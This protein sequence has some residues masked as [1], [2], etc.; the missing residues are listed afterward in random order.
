MDIKKINGGVILKVRNLS[1]GPG[2]FNSGQMGEL[3]V[4]L[5]RLGTLDL[6]LKLGGG[7]VK[8]VR[9]TIKGTDADAE[10]SGS[11]RLRQRMIYSYFRG[12][13]KFK[14]KKALLD[15]PTTPGLLKG[16]INALGTPRGGFHRYKVYFPFRGRPRF[17]KQR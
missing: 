15:R 2:Y 17:T 6:Q 1:L 4:P 10:I 13:I 11:I 3:P 9:C 5:L 12:T 16:A 14:V 8:I 7:Y